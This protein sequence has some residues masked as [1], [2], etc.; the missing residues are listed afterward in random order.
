MAFDRTKGHAALR[1]GRVSI[2]GSNYF[3]TI[4]SDDRR[5][6]LSAPD[7][8]AAI[9]DEIHAMEADG[10]WTCRCAVVMPDHVHALVTLGER[11][12]VGK[13]VGRLKARTAAALQLSDAC[14]LWERGFFDHH[15][16]PDEDRIPVFLYVFLNPYRAGLCRHTE[17][18]AWYECRPLDWSWF[19]EFLDA[20]RP[21]PEWLGQ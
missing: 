1:R 18:W 8:A 13:A 17:H 19:R 6:G 5:P 11:L 9:F 10:T 2:P 21:V 20:D 14:L 4:C 12:S 7:V 15:V 16:R 3:L